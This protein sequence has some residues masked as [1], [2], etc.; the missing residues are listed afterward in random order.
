L[1]EA[2]TTAAA[3][4][5]VPFRAAIEA[6]ATQGRIELA[7]TEAMAPAQPEVDAPARSIT[8]TD[9]ERDVLRLVAEGHTNREI[10]G[11][12]YISEK[13]VSVHVSNVLAKLG[14]LSRY[15]AAA[16]AERLGM[17]G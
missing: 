11:R 13:T 3:M 7:G 10:G 16:S 4:G 5:A 2:P 8:L 6:L 1:R 12:L 17:L 9:R 14:A 15:E